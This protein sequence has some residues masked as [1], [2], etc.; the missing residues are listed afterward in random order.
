MKFTFDYEETL[1]RRIIIDAPRLNDA[2]AELER[3]IDQEEIILN[4]EDFLSAEVRMPLEKNFYPQLQRFGELV[5]DTEDLD[6]LID[7]W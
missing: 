1:S 2:I 5:K 3:R 4:S 6:I 7:C